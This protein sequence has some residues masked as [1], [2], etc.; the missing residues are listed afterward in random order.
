M[1]KAIFNTDSKSPLA[2]SNTNLVAFGGQRIVP[3]GKT[4]LLCKYKEN[5]YLIQFQ[6]ANSVPNVLGLKT[7]TDLNIIKQFECIDL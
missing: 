3:S 2:K 4:T 6:I 1:S 7:S 5:L